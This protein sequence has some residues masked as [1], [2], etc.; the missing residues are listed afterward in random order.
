MQ[1]AL[2]LA[3]ADHRPSRRFY[4]T[5]LGFSNEPDGDGCSI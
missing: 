1:P 3:V 5:W 4:E 2:S